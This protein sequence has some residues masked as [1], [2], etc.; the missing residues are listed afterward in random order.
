MLKL[1][2]SNLKMLFR[3]RQALFWSLM[4]PLLF[5]II[6]GFFFGG[7]QNASG[8]V[9]LI[10][11]SSQDLASNLEKSI[12]K[13]EIF[14]ISK[15]YNLKEAKS[16]I[17]RGKLSAAIVIPE[18]FGN[19]GDPSAPTKIE[20]FDD[21]ANLQTNATIIQYLSQFLTGVNFQ[22]Q[23]AKPIFS[24]KEQK[25]TSSKFEYFDFVLIGLIGMALMN[26]S[27]QGLGVN[28]AKYRE[29]KILKRLT[30]T[31]LK[32]W[33][34]IIAEVLSRLVI[35]FIQISLILIVGIYGF[36]AHING[37]FVI[38]Y[39]I[40]LL[41]AILFQSV[42]FV[43]ASVS[44][45]V[46][47]AEGMSVAVTIPMMFLSGVFFPID[48]LPN[49]LYSIVKYLPLSPLLKMI[50]AVGLDNSSPLADPW[51]LVIIISWIFITLGISIYKF[52]LVEE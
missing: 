4:F 12:N 22:I 52:R 5:T 17:K 38:L 29:T 13:N 45:T 48:A 15:D 21:P 28:M 16:Q 42:G 3:N 51:N 2:I 40:G 9:A 32:S 1:L 6:F 31:P 7:S 20:L 14:K 33:K 8:T 25:T 39:L 10:N 27:I 18:N 34:F 26:S 47:A 41:G 19:L 37:N 30:T 50:R 23:N 24:V 35:N 44:K 36:K 11:N 46:A 49:W 43:V